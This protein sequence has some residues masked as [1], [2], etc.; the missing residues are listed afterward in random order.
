M[1]S[2]KLSH[3][4]FVLPLLLLSTAVDA[5]RPLRS[6]RP[7]TTTPATTPVANENKPDSRSMADMYP[8][9]PI[10]VDSSSLNNGEAK[11]GQRPYYSTVSNGDTERTPL[12]PEFLRKDDA[13]Y[14][15]MVWRELD[16]NEKM[17]QAFNYNAEFDQGSEIFA[18][19]LLNAVINKKVEAFADER[20]TTPLTVQEI[21]RT[22]MGTWDTVEV[23]NPSNIDGPPL[24]LRV[25]RASFD[26]KTIKRLR[27]REEWVFDRESS[28]M[29]VRILAIAPLKTNID[30]QTGRERGYTPMFW[31]YYP[32]LRPVLAKREVYNPKNM[33]MSRMT[34][35]ELFET[36]MFSSFIVKSTIDNAANKTI[37]AMI[38]DP[39]LALLE[40]DNVK[41]KIFN[42]EQDLWSY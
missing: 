41:E 15:Q 27:I 5:Q 34:W 17:N 38:K 28:R 36:R 32:D 40:G 33:G 14:G 23:K 25:T 1:K 7:T 37:R 22:T 3:G 18:N 26:P 16:L 13:L 6:R 10:R 20:F 30:P 31:I 39:M 8:G 11:P 29:F 12:T 19:I 21:E 4:F 2:I 9:I 24:E 42:Y 35:E